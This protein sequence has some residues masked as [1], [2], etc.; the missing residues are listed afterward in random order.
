MSPNVLSMP[1]AVLAWVVRLR[2]WFPLNEGYEVTHLMCSGGRNMAA[3]HSVTV[4]LIIPEEDIDYKIL[5]LILGEPGWDEDHCRKRPDYDL[6]HARVNCHRDHMLDS[7]P[8]GSIFG[9]GVL[10]HSGISL[11]SWSPKGNKL[12]QCAVEDDRIHL[13]VVHDAGTIDRWFRFLKQ[14]WSLDTFR[15]E[16]RREF[17]YS[18]LRAES[19]SPIYIY[20]SP[21][22]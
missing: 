8:E 7:L 9:C 10:W 14:H 6:L 21:R 4:H 13:D 12:R 3:F 20:R 2:H 1:D 5:G 19:R 18:H 22:E 16:G 17:D 15:H 11:L